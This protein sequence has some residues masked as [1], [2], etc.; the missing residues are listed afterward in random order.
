M[1][2][3]VLECFPSSTLSE[4]K[5]QICKTLTS[6]KPNEIYLMHMGRILSGDDFSLSIHQIRSNAK[7]LVFEVEQEDLELQEQQRALQKQNIAQ[8]QEVV[9]EFQGEQHESFLHFCLEKYQKDVPETIMQL[10]S[11]S[12]FLKQEFH[13]HKRGDGNPADD[14]AASF[15]NNTEAREAKAKSDTQADHRQEENELARQAPRDSPDQRLLEA[16]IL[17]EYKAMLSSDDKLYEILFKFLEI[18]SPS[19]QQN[20]WSYLQ[21]LPLSESIV[22]SIL[23]EIN[24]Q[25]YERKISF[26]LPEFND[27][28]YLQPLQHRQSSLFFQESQSQALRPQQSQFAELSQENAESSTCQ[29]PSKPK[30]VERSQL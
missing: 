2:F 15:P 30:Q 1:K 25:Q 29:Q 6:F 7:I 27:D 4:L 26:Q 20:I 23:K 21:K 13:Q 22:Q 11:I 18:K 9:P 28:P 12:D 24:T 3:P 14:A 16:R 19:L 8:I 17:A 5:F 10:M